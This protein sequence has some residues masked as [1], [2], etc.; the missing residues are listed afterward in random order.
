MLSLWG[1]NQSNASAADLR[2][3]VVYSRK[4]ATGQIMTVPGRNTHT[5]KQPKNSKAF[6]TLTAD[7]QATGLDR[8]TKKGTP[9]S[10]LLQKLRWDAEQIAKDEAEGRN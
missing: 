10:A 8:K 4:L 9:A 3:P 1:N 7:A 2:T 5:G 6:P